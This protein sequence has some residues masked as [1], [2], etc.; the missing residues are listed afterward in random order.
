MRMHK[1]RVLISIILYIREFK[2]KFK[3]TLVLESR[4]HGFKK[5]TGVENLVEQSL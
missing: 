4:E 2:T 1:I 5:K 3:M